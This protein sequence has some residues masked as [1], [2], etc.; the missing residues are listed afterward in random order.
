MER[1]DYKNKYIKY[2]QKYTNAL[3]NMYGGNPNL[4]VTL[5][6]AFKEQPK[7][8]YIVDEVTNNNVKTLLSL[9]EGNAFKTIN[10]YTDCIDR[11]IGISN[12]N[13]LKI[14][15]MAE[16]VGFELD[17][18]P[19]HPWNGYKKGIQKID[20]SNAPY[21]NKV[22]LEFTKNSYYPTL[23]YFGKNPKTGEY[24]SVTTR[25]HLLNAKQYFERCNL[26]KPYIIILSPN[27][28]LHF[29]GTL[30]A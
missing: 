27:N 25:E 10:K 2:K 28:T 17:T 24:H 19:N 18:H 7:A 4:N 1:N 26:S 21:T 6:D 3:E 16:I 13:V 11:L 29:Y 5:N 20:G 15:P 30:Y 22:K 23:S 8:I 14:I 12:K 9:S